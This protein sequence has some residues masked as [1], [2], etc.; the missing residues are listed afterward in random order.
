MLLMAYCIPFAF[1]AVN[2]DATSGTMLFYGVMAAGLAALCWCALKTNNIGVLYAGNALCY[3]SSRLFAVLTG[4]GPMEAHF[5]PFTSYTMMT[6]VSV[7]A[8]IIQSM[9]AIAFAVRRKK[10]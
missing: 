9:A 3:A 1:L 10:G 4:L 7:L 5:K 8:V 2:G 6:L